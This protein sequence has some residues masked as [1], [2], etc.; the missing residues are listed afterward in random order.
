MQ[1]P[2][3]QVARKLRAVRRFLIESLASR[4]AGKERDAEII[5][6][7]SIMLRKWMLSTVAGLTLLIPLAVAPAAQAK[8][9]EAPREAYHHHR[10]E[11]MYRRCGADPWVCYGRFEER[12]EAERAEHFMRHQGYEAFVRD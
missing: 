9:P 4:G 12:R 10:Y 7:D 11:V 6:E 5:P 2:Q 8:A 3:R 1:A